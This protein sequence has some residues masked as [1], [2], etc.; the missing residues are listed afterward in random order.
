MR[1]NTILFTNNDD[2]VLELTRNLDNNAGGFLVEPHLEH[3]RRPLRSRGRPRHLA[4][5]RLLHRPSALAWHHYAF[6]I[7]TTASAANQIL[8]T[9]TAKPSR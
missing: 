3:L 9:S 1:W 8:A 4:Q 5:Q 7:N 2:Q 6:V